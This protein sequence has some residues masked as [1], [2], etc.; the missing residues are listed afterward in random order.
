[1]QI[2]ANYL[3]SVYTVIVI[4]TYLIYKLEHTLFGILFL[5]LKLHKI[6]NPRLTFLQSWSSC[7]Q[8]Q[9]LIIKEEKRRKRGKKEKKR[10]NNKR[11][12]R[13]KYVNLE[14]EEGLAPLE[15]LPAFFAF[16][17]AV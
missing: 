9:Q 16:C 8:R 5:L 11:K 1:M 17:F 14:G 6:N 2:L 13:K 4:C 7:I 15:Q 3:I 10:K 12:R